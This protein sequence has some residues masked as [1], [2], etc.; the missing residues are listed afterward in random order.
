MCV[1]V[2]VY[3]SKYTYL[4]IYLSLTLLLSF[5]VVYNLFF[6]GKS[7]TL[8]V[9][10]TSL[11]LLLTMSNFLRMLLFVVNEA[12]HSMWRLYLGASELYSD[13]A[14]SDTTVLWGER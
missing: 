3:I 2:C 13:R 7:L 4:S 1:C 8:K 9:C 5:I 10:W 6:G 11:L 14:C 12:V